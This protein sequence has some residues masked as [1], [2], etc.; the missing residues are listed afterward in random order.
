MQ[1]SMP[2]ARTS[3]FSMPKRID[4]VLVPFD[5]GAVLHGGIFDWHEIAQGAFGNDEAADMLGKVARE[6]DQFL[7]QAA[8]SSKTSRI[9]RDRGRLRLT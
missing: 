9:A 5:D 7:G 6:I 8:W 3:I 4:I 2:R 1:V